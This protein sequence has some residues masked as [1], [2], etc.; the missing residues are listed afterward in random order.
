MKKI[1]K[2]FL[3]LIVLF[4]AI[5]LICTYIGLNIFELSA[6]AN[7]IVSFLIQIFGLVGGLL[8]VF[9]IHLIGVVILWVSNNGSK[10][11]SAMILGL[12]LL[13]T[14]VILTHVY[15]IVAIMTI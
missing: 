9:I 4:T 1:Y 7:P 11:I 14:G 5:D 15:W 2:V 8:V 13:K 12:L 3:V 10:I 6:E